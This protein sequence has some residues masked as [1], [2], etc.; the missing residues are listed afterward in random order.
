LQDPWGQNGGILDPPGTLRPLRGGKQDAQ[1]VGG[2]KSK[3]GA[4][5]TVRVDGRWG[6]L[7]RRGRWKGRRVQNLELERKKEGGDV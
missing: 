2:E 6:E 3:R 1:D 7:R 4:K 5:K